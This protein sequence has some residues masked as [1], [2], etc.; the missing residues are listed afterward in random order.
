[1]VHHF[2]VSRFNLPLWPRDKHD[3]RIDRTAWLRRRIELFERYTL[4]SVAGQ[5]CREFV[6]VLLVDRATPA[7]ERPRI[8]AFRD[9]CPMLRLCALDERQVH[10]AGFGAP[11]VISALLQE[12]GAQPD[13][14]VLTTYL[15]TDDALA[16][17]Y[18]ACI[19][20]AADE[21]C[22]RVPLPFAMSCDHGL[23]YFERTG[24][25][26]SLRHPHSHFM[27]IAERAATVR[28]CYGY[29]SHLYLERDGF[30]VVHLHEH[31]PMWCEV[32][33][34]GNVDNDVKMTLRFHFVRDLSLLRT[35]FCIAAPMRCTPRAIARWTADAAREFGKQLRYKVHPR[36]FWKQ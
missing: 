16:A 6:F 22:Q 27:T 24:L 36:D 8:R 14:T 18:V 15:D 35:R 3:S 28:T 34:E 20:H 19:R 23:Q 10:T 12:R 9:Q 13:D 17:D 2:I 32:V 11:I 33:H 31:R 29:G 7:E 25:T 5:T 1:M 4:P 26:V 21:L 30:R